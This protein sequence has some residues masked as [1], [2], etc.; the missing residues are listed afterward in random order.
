MKRWLHHH[1]D[2]GWKADGCCPLEQHS[3]VLRRLHAKRRPNGPQLRTPSRRPHARFRGHALAPIRVLLL[4]AVASAPVRV[5]PRGHP[6]STRLRDPLRCPIRCAHGGTSPPSCVDAP[7]PC[8]GE[9]RVGA[10]GGG[11][12]GTRRPCHPPPRGRRWGW[13]WKGPS[14]RPAAAAIK[15]AVGGHPDIVAGR[16]GHGPLLQQTGPRHV[17]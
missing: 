2:T 16:Q 7:T 5:P 6:C 11:S 3:T 13:G 10:G 8:V 12:G 1:P 9:G 17:G 15:A 14:R 4:P